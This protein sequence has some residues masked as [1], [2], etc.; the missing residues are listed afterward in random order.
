MNFM[1][2]FQLMIIFRELGET[3]LYFAVYFNQ[4]EIC[5]ILINHGAEADLAD[6]VRN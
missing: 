3:P 2:Y 4:P 1:I 5:R 6:K